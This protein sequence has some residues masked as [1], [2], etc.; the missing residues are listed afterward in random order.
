MYRVLL[1]SK[2]LIMKKHF[3]TL[4]G[5]DNRSKTIILLV[6]AVLLISVSLIVGTGDNLPMIAMFF[7]GLI[8]F[9]FAILHLW[10]KASYFAALTAACFVILIMDFIWPFINED[11]AMP[12]GGVCFAGIITGIIGIFTR[13]KSWKRLPLAGS[14]LSLIA[15]GIF[16]TSLNIPLRDVIEPWKE[17]ALICLQLFITIL[18][19]SIGLINK[20]E[21][22]LTKAILILSAL[23]LI[24]L[25]AW[26]F[27]A[28]TWQYGEHTHSIIFVKLMARIYASVDII[29][30]C[31]SIYACKWLMRR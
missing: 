23:V 17:W 8:F 6:T 14:L 29:I 3:I 30:A 13:L 21:S 31:L 2:S 15:M 19:F 11:I 7:A 26:G 12:A 1:L 18:L 9:F 16:I 28:S 24:M 25:S 20:K 5:P 10:T 22:H 27:Y 4:F